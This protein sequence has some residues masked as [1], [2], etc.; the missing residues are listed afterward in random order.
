MTESSL[1]ERFKEG[2]SQSI[3]GRRKN[4]RITSVGR[5]CGVSEFGELIKV[6]CAIMDGRKMILV[7]KADENDPEAVKTT[8]ASTGTPYVYMAKIC[9]SWFGDDRT[10]WNKDLELIESQDG[11]DLYEVVEE[12]R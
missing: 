3:R 6:R 12:D 5:L 8:P 1:I 11:S 10:K 2:T 9:K 7:S 4:A